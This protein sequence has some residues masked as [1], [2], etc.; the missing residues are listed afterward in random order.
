MESFYKN[1]LK[2]NNEDNER[3]RQRILIQNPIPS[4]SDYPM[5]STSS[6]SRDPIPST[7]SAHSLSIA[8]NSNL[9]SSTS[10]VHPAASKPVNV[11]SD[12]VYQK[13]GLQLLV[14]RALFQRQK[15]FSL[16]AQTLL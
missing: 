12:I 2:R 7:S 15:K 8:V 16:Q 5:P 9:S 3:A 11:D 13:D 14:E 10:H 1:W 6:A 4:S